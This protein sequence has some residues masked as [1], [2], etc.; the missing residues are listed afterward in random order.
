[1][2]VSGLKN[3]Y[4]YSGYALEVSPG[5][6]LSCKVIPAVCGGTVYLGPQI[7]WDGKTNFFRDWDD[8][9]IYWFTAYEFG[10]SLK[11]IFN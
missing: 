8:S 2:S 9:H 10:P 4:K 7:R 3:R 11:W 5:Y 1:M 6:T